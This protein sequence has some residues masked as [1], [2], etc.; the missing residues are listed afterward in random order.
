MV[1]MVGVTIMAL[2]L[3]PVF[4]SIDEGHAL[5]NRLVVLGYVVMRVAMVFMW[6]RA[7]RQ[8]PQHRATCLTYIWTIVL[9]QLG[10]VATALFP[11]TLLQMCVAGAVLLLVELCGPYLAETRH[12][13]TPWHAHHIAERYGLL[14]IIALGE[15]VVGSVASLSAVVEANGWTLDAALVVVAGLGLTFGMWWAYFLLSAGEVLHARRDRAYKWAYGGM[16]IFA[17]IA[18]TGAGLHVAALAIENK[19]HIGPVAAVLAVTIPVAIYLL[20]IYWLYSVLYDERHWFH[21]LLLAST[22]AVLAAAPVA[23]SLGVALPACLL[24]LMLA[25]AVSVVGYE[26]YGYR[27]VGEALRRATSS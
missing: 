11:L 17:A 23:A 10:W 24:I 21:G 27:H 2:G 7:A 9:A 13:G 5:D 14:A 26:A 19:A 25:P 12:G 20:G 1:Q 8:S 3:P 6:A 15:G 22:G 4:H 18:A 16:P